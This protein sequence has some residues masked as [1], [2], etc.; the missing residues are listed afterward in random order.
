MSEDAISV[1]LGCASSSTPELPVF[2]VPAIFL[3]PDA[4]LLLQS[5]DG[6]LFKIF[7]AFLIVGCQFFR[8]MFAHAH[9]STATSDEPVKWDEPATVIIAL[10]YQLYPC[11]KPKITTVDDL[12]R[13]AEAADKW[14]MYSLSDKCIRNLAK[15]RFLDQ[16][17][18]AVYR[19][20]SRFRIDDLKTKASYR[21]VEMF[22]PLEA[23]RSDL[24]GIS[25]IE[26]VQLCDLRKKR[27]QRVQNL[28]RLGS[29]KLCPRHEGTIQG[30]AIH[31]SDLSKLNDHL[32]T[33]AEKTPS[34]TIISTV[35]NILD[36][37]CENYG[38]K[39]ED[40][41]RV[42]KERLDDYSTFV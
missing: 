42:L 31:G 37:K 6:V 28:C 4:D 9:A 25:G 13:M 1:Y 33:M 41:L 23:L 18:L 19:F 27:I 36:C 2:D 10:L 38:C 39:L 5:S 40:H 15:R 3:D 17:P 32:K 24:V 14:G 30:A 7:K 29:A 11:T 21:V 26:V 8:D 22:D 20:A 16:R 34:S 12:I 35:V